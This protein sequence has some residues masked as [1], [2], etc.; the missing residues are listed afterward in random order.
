MSRE[1]KFKAWDKSK[2]RWLSMHEYDARIILNAF[3]DD[4]GFELNEYD[5]KH[6]KD[7]GINID[8]VQYTGL[9]DKNGKEVYEGDIVNCSRGCPHEV[10]WLQEYGGKFL[11]GM[12]AFYLS[13]LNEGYA[14]T[15][16]EEI[17]GNIYEKEK[18]Q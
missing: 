15:G 10:I 14:W 6:A 13:G 7:L 2:R 1:I 3:V 11:G 16:E 12:P 8:V 4:S 18:S 9:K 17:V 5:G